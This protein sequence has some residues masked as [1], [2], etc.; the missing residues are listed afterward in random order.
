MILKKHGN[1]CGQLVAVCHIIITVK[2]KNTITKQR[3]RVS[4]FYVYYVLK[5]STST[6]NCVCMCMLSVLGLIV[7]SFR[8]CVCLLHI[9]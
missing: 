7:Q 1:F 2:P 5:M 8:V 6:T 4:I 9:A 3:L